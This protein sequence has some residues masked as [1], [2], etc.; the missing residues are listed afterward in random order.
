MSKLGEKIREIPWRKI[1]LGLGLLTL[2]ALF[3][4]GGYLLMNWYLQGRSGTDSKSEYADWQA[5]SNEAYGFGLRYPEDWEVT[6]ANPTFIIFEPGAGEEEEMGEAGG[7]EEEVKE[8]VSLVVASNDG[9]AKTACE[10]D[11][12]QCSFHANGI[13]GDRTS[14]PEME[15]VFFSHGESDFSLTLFRY[16]SSD[17]AWAGYKAL[18]EEMATSFR[19]T[20]QTTLSC[21]E[22]GDCALGIR[23][24]KCCVCA[25]AF[26]ASEIEASTAIAPYE[27][28]KDYSGERAID[29]TS[30]Y[31]SACPAEPSGV[32]CVSNRCQIKE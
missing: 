5:Y 31:C 12:S 15:I 30:V 7:T 16:D 2:V 11:Q 29:C 4:L 24:D 23:L 19:F 32:I 27:T 25:E 9:R 6:E 20:T 14:T 22:D 21:E 8:Y 17:E 26:T 13:F 18:F 10:E 3:F 28:G 1:G